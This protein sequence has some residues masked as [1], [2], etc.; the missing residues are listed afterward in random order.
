M[1]ASYKH[2]QLPDITVE[3]KT[4]MQLASIPFVTIGI[5]SPLHISTPSL[6]PKVLRKLQHDKIRA[7]MVVPYWPNAP[8]YP[9]FHKIVE[10]SIKINE[11]LYLDDTNKLR[12]APS[13]PT[14]IA[15]VNGTHLPLINT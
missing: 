1:F 8:W 5:W 10:R 12:P 13:W 14:I 2:H 9:I 3:T 15:I 7:M 11:P 6:I 4:L